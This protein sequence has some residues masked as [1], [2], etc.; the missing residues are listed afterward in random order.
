M[1]ITSVASSAAT[2]STA[3]SSTLATFCCR[4][5]N[6]IISLRYAITGFGDFQSFAGLQDWFLGSKTGCCCQPK[7]WSTQGLRWRGQSFGLEAAGSWRTNGQPGRT[8]SRVRS[9]NVWS[10]GVI[11][12]SA[13]LVHGNFQCVF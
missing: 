4:S 2:T 6:S 3:S 13:L 7:G 11:L 12:G 8:T 1:L 10:V 9:R 5:A